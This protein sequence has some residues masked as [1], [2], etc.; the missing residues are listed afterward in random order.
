[1]TGVEM[2][3]V[4][5]VII[6]VLGVMLAGGCGGSAA[7]TPMPLPTST[8]PATHMPGATATEVPASPGGGDEDGDGVVREVTV[9]PELVA[10]EGPFPQQCMVVDGELFYGDIDGFEY[11]AGYR[12]RLRIERYDSFPGQTE[13][14]QDTGRYGYRL[15][16]LLEK[17]RD[18]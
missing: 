13:I 10:C 12:Y 1:M 14:P 11:E 8:P 18:R 16:A 15:V 2:R 17:E 9:G 7:P 4:A 5:I 6:A 3:A